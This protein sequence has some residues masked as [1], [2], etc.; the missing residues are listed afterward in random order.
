MKLAWQAAAFLL[1]TATLFTGCT[2]EKKKNEDPAASIDVRPSFPVRFATGKV[3]PAVVRI[4]VVTET[5]SQ[6]QPR[7]SRSLGSG[8]IIDNQGFILTN[9]HVA[10]RAKRLDVTLSNLEHVR[11][12]L[13][14]SDHWTDLALIQLDLDELKRKNLTFS[15]AELGRSSDVSLAQPVMAVGTPYGLSRT[16]TAGII[17]NTDRYFEESSIGE[18]ETG[19]FNNWLQMDAAINPGNSGGPLINWR[20]E[21]VGIN[22]RGSPT[23]NNL[24]FAIP[25]DVAKDVVKQLRSDG[26]VTRSYIGAQLQPLQDLETFYDVPGNKGVLVASVEKDSPAANAGLKAEDV[27]VAVDG[28]PVSARF[29]EELAP[30]R[31]L[32]S[33]YAVGS[34]LQLQVRRRGETQ[35]RVLAVT[36][37]KLESKITEE[38][39]I[40]AWGLSVRDLTRAYLREKRIPYVKGVLV[41]G[42]RPGSV[43]ETAQFRNGDIILKVDNK[44][45]TT[46]EELE[47]VVAAWEK[48][49]K[50]A[51][52]DIQ[53]DRGT[54]LLVI[55][56]RE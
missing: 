29:P 7:S 34:V 18:Y 13:I 47:K 41:T 37:E 38:K 54:L 36:T 30:V 40:A 24:G 52:V 26:K 33:D 51:G 25:I 39:S 27:L 4:D 16:V 11:A 21:V 10:G 56:P 45:V 14:G 5:F 19:W 23:A 15:Y 53:R 31:K 49:P 32:L 8:V 48:N 17:S 6:G 3:S 44:P 22:T 20:G 28:K 55:K 35:P 1:T 12:K 46:A 50:V 9:F 42:A 43:G 2:T